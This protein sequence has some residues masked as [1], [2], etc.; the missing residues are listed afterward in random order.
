MDWGPIVF[1]FCVVVFC[2]MFLVGRP[3]ARSLHGDPRAAK[4]RRTG[5]ALSPV[6]EIQGI[7]S[8]MPRGDEDRDT[9]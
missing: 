2:L 8:D 3:G 7:P 9:R 1:L 6:Q 5:S 4:R